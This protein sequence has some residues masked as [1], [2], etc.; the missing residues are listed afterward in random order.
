MTRVPTRWLAAI[1]ATTL[2]AAMPAPTLADEAILELPDDGFMSG[3]LLPAAGPDDRPLHS[4]IWKSALFETPFTFPI[5]AVRG[6]CFPT[7][8]AALP[9]GAWRLV[10]TDGDTL[11]GDLSGIDA[12]AITLTGPT[13]SVVKIDRRL[14]ATLERIPGDDRT[15]L[16]ATDTLTNWDI[17]PEGAWQASSTGLVSQK[18]PSTL[19]RDAGIPDRAR[20]DIS[21][22]VANGASFRLA[23]GALALPQATDPF[24]VELLSGKGEP[25]RLALVRQ[26]A[27]AAKIVEIDRSIVADGRITLTL[28]I[29]QT[30][31]RIAATAPADKGRE[32]I[33]DVTVPPPS[34]R[35]PSRLMRM[36]AISGDIVIESIRVSSWTTPDPTLVVAPETVVT[37]DQGALERT[38]VESLDLSSGSLSLSRDGETRVVPLGSVSVIAFPPAQKAPRPEIRATDVS[39]TGHRFTVAAN[40]GQR[41]T[42]VIARIGDGTVWLRREGIDGDIALRRE[43]VQSLRRLGPLANVDG[44]PGRPGT[45]SAAGVRC[46]GCM[47]TH[48]DQTRQPRLAW[49]PRESTDASLFAD[50]SKVDAVVEYGS[51]V[52]TKKAVAGDP[53][54]PSRLILRSGDAVPC[55]VVSLNEQAIGVTTP[56]AGDGGTVLVTATLAQAVELIPAAPSRGLEKTRV[57]RLLTLPR[58]QRS[59]PPRHILRLEDGDYIRGTV[60]SFAPDAFSIAV[61]GAMRT[62]P[63]STVA[64]VIWLTP[65]DTPGSIPWQA[66]TISAANLPPECML[67][68]AIAADGRRITLNAS[69]MMGDDIIGENPAMGPCRIT[70][71]HIDRLQLGRAVE[72]DVISLPYSQWKLKHAPEPRVLREAAGNAG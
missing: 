13:G 46:R 20:Y 23:V 12:A 65:P 69:R 14:A 21:L 10:L 22:S 70:I 16:V 3:R 44:L 30:L 7:P 41:L 43:D 2:L 53:S 38:T 28:F 64:R 5:G 6:V 67:V 71:R 24:R 26:E 48:A 47:T 39:M 36:T 51:P 68:R 49:Q 56:I 18:C 37:D 29:D 66:E 62:V 45:L 55:R 1:T 61:A 27:S 59:D 58:S 52:T 9:Y 31:G 34:D 4:L 35:M 33:G 15:T 8:V 42:A 17:S 60:K 57:E 54:F 50:P 32:L 40:G 63:P 72:R 19:S 25:A 11:T